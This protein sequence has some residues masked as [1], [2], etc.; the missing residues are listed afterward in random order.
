M[1]DLGYEEGI[2]LDGIIA[3]CRRNI[4]LHGLVWNI[5]FGRSLSKSRNGN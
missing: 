3:T 4:M 2:T 1:K 5:Q